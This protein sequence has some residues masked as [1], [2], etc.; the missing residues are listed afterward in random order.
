MELT[1]TLKNSFDELIEK[2]ITEM[3]LNSIPFSLVISSR[4]W[5]R[6][7]PDNLKKQEFFVVQIKEQTLDDSYYDQ[8]LN[9][10]VIVTEFNN[11]PNSVV[12]DPK[13]VQGILSI[14]MKN[15]IIMKPYR[16]E[17]IVVGNIG[18]INVNSLFAEGELTSDIANSVDCFIKN[19]PS[20]FSK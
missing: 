12:V 15:P 11:Q 7:L 6:P 4:N 1:E 13:S 18:N 8:S 14:D 3:V 9:K 16:E 5:D 10:I 19:N 17:P 20:M 2:S